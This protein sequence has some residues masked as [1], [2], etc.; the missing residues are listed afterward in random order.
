[1]RRLLVLRTTFEVSTETQREM[2]PHLEERFDTCH[3]E[4]WRARRSGA[5]GSEVEIERQRDRTEP[6]YRQVGTQRERD[7]VRARRRRVCRAG[8]ESELLGGRSYVIDYRVR[9][10]GCAL[11]LRR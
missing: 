8:V 5:F 1:M 7:V 10:A 4:R 3:T 11:R 6:C 9:D 2:R